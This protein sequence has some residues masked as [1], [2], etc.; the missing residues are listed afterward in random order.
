MKLASAKLPVTTEVIDKNTPPRVGYEAVEAIDLGPKVI[1]RGEHE[2]NLLRQATEALATGGVLSSEV[3]ST[4][5][6]A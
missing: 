3:A 6:S 5:P 1:T 2:A 4:Q